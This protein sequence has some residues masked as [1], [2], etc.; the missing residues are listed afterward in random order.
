MLIFSDAIARLQNASRYQKVFLPKDLTTALDRCSHDNPTDEEHDAVIC[1]FLKHKA[2]RFHQREYALPALRHLNEDIIAVIHREYRLQKTDIMYPNTDPVS[3]KN[4]PNYLASAWHILLNAK[5]F[6]PENQQALA[7]CKKPQQQSSLYPMV[8]ILYLLASMGLLNQGTFDFVV[9]CKT[10]SDLL[11]AII[12]LARVQLLNAQCISYFIHDEYVPP[13]GALLLGLVC[14]NHTLLTEKNFHRMLILSPKEM[15]NAHTELT[16][17]HQYALIRHLPHAE[18]G[19][20]GTSIQRIMDTLFMAVRVEHYNSRT[21]IF[22]LLHLNEL[23][24]KRL[25][26]C[27]LHPQNNDTDEIEQL[28]LFL[29]RK[30][31]DLLTK[32]ILATVFAHHAA[33]GFQS[34]VTTLAKANLLNQDNLMA[35]VTHR[36]QKNILNE[37][38]RVNVS[39]LTQPVLD[40]M[41]LLSHVD[42][43][44]ELIDMLNQVNLC[45]ENNLLYFAKHKHPRTLAHLL[46]NMRLTGNVLTQDMYTVL[47]SCPHLHILTALMPLVPLLAQAHL[48]TTENI[49]KSIYYWSGH[50]ELFNRNYYNHGPNDIAL[51]VILT[52]LL[53]GG[54]H[55]VT[56]EHLNLIFKHRFPHAI[57][58]ALELFFFKR[59]INCPLDEQGIALL[60]SEMV[61][62]LLSHEDI[63]SLV[64]RLER[65]DNSDEGLTKDNLNGL[66]FTPVEKN[67]LLLDFHAH[68]RRSSS[69][70]DASSSYNEP[71]RRYS[72]DSY[73]ATV[74]V[75]KARGMSYDSV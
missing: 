74:K 45:N 30:H 1:A 49:S 21:R 31:P 14:T 54:A 28:I 24:S 55:L 2:V 11:L 37:L 66:F 53:R 62:I 32:K 6:T 73:E 60:T 58:R 33:H 34:I 57:I 36:V 63:P 51:C 43:S 3:V 9:H 13:L 56:Q 4:Q 39:L 48:L 16:A 50:F 29:S 26:L 19:N 71:L 59:D 23:L 10:P 35:C 68:R 20:T 38:H 52:Y 27:L 72:Q 8:K 12:A 40:A 46:H 44:I 15:E 18:N 7:G 22:Q 65:L 42:E 69:T 5:L 67:S 61:T 17:L 25:V 70:S 41:P 64:R 75:S 47:R